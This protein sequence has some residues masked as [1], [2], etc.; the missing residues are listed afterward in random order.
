VEEPARYDTRDDPLLYGGACGVKRP[1]ADYRI[2]KIEAQRRGPQSGFKTTV[3]SVIH[4]EDGTEHAHQ[5]Y[6]GADEWD[7]YWLS[8]IHLNCWSSL[9]TLF[10]CGRVVSDIPSGASYGGGARCK[11]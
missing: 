6:L 8:F 9:D 4:Y 3:S 10:F 7:M 1:V 2:T 11:S 5:F